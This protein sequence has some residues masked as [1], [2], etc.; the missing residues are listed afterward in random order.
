MALQDFVAKVKQV[1]VA[2]ANKFAV[3]F[4]PPTVVRNKM[5]NADLNMILMFCDQAALPDQNVST[6]QLRTYGEVREMPYENLYGNINMSFICDSDFHVKT[7]FDT[8]IQN[9]SDPNTR[10][11][12]YY[13]DYTSNE[14]SIMMMNM[15]GKN[16]Y[17][18]KLY[19]CYPKQVQ[20]I[21]VDYASKD[22]VKV[23]VSM[24]YKYWRSFPIS[25]TRVTDPSQ[26]S[27]ISNLLPSFY[28]DSSF[29]IINDRANPA[30]SWVPQQYMNSF[31]KYQSMYNDTLNS[32]SRISSSI[33]DPQS[34]I[35]GLGSK[36]SGLF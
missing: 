6:A 24:N 27:Q 18:V 14:I 21:T 17:Q 9:I 16:V 1:G 36:F 4:T 22:F 2:P 13:R 32:V 11:M 3:T 29:D 28:D 19:E 23:Q 10:H 25:D 8:W 26:T 33:G 7:F 12:N 34:I 35:T 31:D 15:A 5:P 30:F 20:A